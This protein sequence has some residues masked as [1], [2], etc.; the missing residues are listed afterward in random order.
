VVLIVDDL[1]QGTPA[2]AWAS[3]SS[4]ST[5][6]PL[7]LPVPR[8][9]VVVS[10][11]PDDE[12][13]GAGGLM[14]ALIADAVPL[15]VVSVTDG[16]AS[17]PRSTVARSI[18]LRSIRAAECHDALRRLGW[19]TPGITRVGIPDG[20]VAENSGYLQQ[21]LSALLRPGDL[22]VAP[23]RLDGHPDHDAC[24]EAVAAV[25][26]ELGLPTLG[27]LIWAWHWADPGGSDIPWASCRR[28]DLSPRR[29][30]RKRWA[31]AAFRSQTR[32]LGPAPEDAAILPDPLL[33]RLWPSFEIFIDPRAERP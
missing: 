30:A 19:P 31:A 11:H 24:G 9:V 17:H 16:E 6:A 26:G 8:R 22:C 20:R 10:P 21:R 29:R 14:Q 27:Y 4:L 33:R 5:V 1:N 13:L 25:G 18:D 7:T 12:V 3:S 2:S 23:W 15:H 28:I 32:P